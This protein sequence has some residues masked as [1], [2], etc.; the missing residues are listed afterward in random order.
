MTP[1]KM[2]VETV[3][4]IAEVGNWDLTD[5]RA[6]EIARIFQPLYDDTRVLRQMD[7]GDSAPDTVFEAD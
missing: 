7:L 4:T 2:T 6:E 5:E 3:K 1:P